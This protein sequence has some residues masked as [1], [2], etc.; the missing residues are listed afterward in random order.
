MTTAGQAKKIKEEEAEDAYNRELEDS[1]NS[2]QRA[3]GGLV[4]KPKTNLEKFRG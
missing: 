1:I 2:E 3:L 4:R